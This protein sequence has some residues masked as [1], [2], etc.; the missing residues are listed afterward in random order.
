VRKKECKPGIGCVTD[1]PLPRY[2]TLK[3][4]EGKARRGPGFEHRIDW[5]FV[6]AGMP[7]RLTAEFDNWRRVEDAEGEG[8]W[9]HYTL[10]SG[11]ARSVLVMQDL[12]EFLTRPDDLADVVYQSERG[13]IGRVIECSVDWCRVAIEGQRGWV[14]KGA[15]WGVDPQEVVE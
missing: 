13:V 3:T 10:L 1:R 6:R 7:L 8:G 15:L 9:M 14:R 5:L 2:V 4:D 11:S 12:T